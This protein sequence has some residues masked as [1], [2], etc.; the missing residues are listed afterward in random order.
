MFLSAKFFGQNSEC[1]LPIL[2][3][4]TEFR[5][6]SSAEW[7]R[8]E[9]QVVASIHGAEFRVVFSSVEGVRTEFRDFASIFVPQY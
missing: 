6:F 3:H 2:F 7:F 9:L 1:L 5:V 4:E 8:K